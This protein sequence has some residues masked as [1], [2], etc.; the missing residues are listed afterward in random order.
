LTWEEKKT[1]EIPVHNFPTDNIV[2]VDTAMSQLIKLQEIVHHKTTTTM[3]KN[4]IF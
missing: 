3:K 2:T 1:N 4:Q